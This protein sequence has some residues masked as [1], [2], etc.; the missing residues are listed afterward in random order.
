MDDKK[1]EKLVAFAKD[2]RDICKKYNASINGCGCCGS[3]WVD[4]DDETV[5]LEFYI[6]GNREE[7]YIAFTRADT[8]VT[9]HIHNQEENN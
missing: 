5:A 2:I 1:Y 8:Y 9:I 6:D 4:L 7:S 3:P